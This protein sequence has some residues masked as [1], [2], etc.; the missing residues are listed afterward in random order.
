MLD[1]A[2]IYVILVH[3]MIQSGIG[4]TKIDD[5]SRIQTV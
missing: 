5:K 1:M 3:F 4:T 2:I